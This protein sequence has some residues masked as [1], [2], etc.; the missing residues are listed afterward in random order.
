MKAISRSLLPRGLRLMHPVKQFLEWFPE[1]DFAVLD[2][3]FAR[4]GRDYYVVAETLF[5]P[6][7]GRYLLLFTHVVTAAIV[8][9]VRDDV[10][11]DS[12]DDVFTDYAA[13]ERAGEPDGYVWGSNWTLAYPGLWAVEPSPRAL[14][15]T[16]RLGR[17]MYEAVLETDRFELTLVFHSLRTKK[18]DDRTDLVSQVVFPL[19]E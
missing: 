11:T 18:I 4:H 14:E 5:G 3:G 10:W 9:R 17:P 1:N 16:S 2:H 12:W 19:K 15:W 8:T 7:P 13:W 6:D